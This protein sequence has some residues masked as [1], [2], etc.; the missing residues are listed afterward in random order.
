VT[1]EFAV[2]C[3]GKQA[4]DVAVIEPVRQGPP[5]D[6]DCIVRLAI[7]E[8]HTVD[9]FE[10]RRCEQIHAHAVD[11]KT[12]PQ[13]RLNGKGGVAPSYQNVVITAASHGTQLRQAGEH[14]CTLHHKRFD[15]GR[16]QNV[17]SSRKV[18]RAGHVLEPGLL[19][20]SPY[21]QELRLIYLILDDRF[22]QQG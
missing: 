9:F 20:S 2:F 5:V 4:V 18:T 22:D 11:L 19:R 7:G 17:K 15:A 1:Y 14:G 12:G 21:S 8:M 16:C 6:I 3:A 10:V 13:E